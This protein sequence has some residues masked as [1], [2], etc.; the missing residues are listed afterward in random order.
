MTSW[1]RALGLPMPGDVPLG[2]GGLHVAIVFTP[3][4]S[5]SLI[6]MWLVADCDGPGAWRARGARR[7]GTPR[8]R[9][10]W[11]ISW[12]STSGRAGT[13]AR[14]R[15]S[16]RWCCAR[17]RRPIAYGLRRSPR[18]RRCRAACPCIGTRARRARAGRSW[19][20]P[21]TAPCCA[22]MGADAGTG[23]AS[24]RARARDRERG[25]RR[26]ACAARVGR[27]A[28]RRARAR[29]HPDAWAPRPLPHGRAP[30]HAG[31]DALVEWSYGRAPPLLD[32]GTAATLEQ[33][34]ALY[35]A[36]MAVRQLAH[37]A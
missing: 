32:P 11:S 18:R 13:S 7:G 19:S 23:A 3:A 26:G 34:H 1:M 9:G 20:S 5:S 35:R 37:L 15:R 22:W 31:T 30:L 28:P 6:G 2:P 4:F 24:L 36:L 29:R 16:V 8:S 33:V 27:G 17:S 21:T 14:S 12:P 25:H 10:W